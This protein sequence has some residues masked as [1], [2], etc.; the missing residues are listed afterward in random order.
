M[1]KSISSQGSRSQ[2]GQREGTTKEGNTANESELAQ[3]RERQRALEQ[4]R[5]SLER[6]LN[7]LDTLRSQ[8]R[9]VKTELWQ[10]KIA[11][12]RQRDADKGAGGNRG[13]LMQGGQ[14]QT[15]GTP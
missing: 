4:E 7:D 6:Q 5:A 14:W 9:K 15:V 2:R 8:V 3:M 10:E 11:A 12:W 1:A 13:V